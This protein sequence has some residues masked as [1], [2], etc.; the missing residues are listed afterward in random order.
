MERKG[1]R[2]PVS[3]LPPRNENKNVL[4]QA[5]LGVVGVGKSKQAPVV[6][7]SGFSK[8]EEV[9]KPLRNSSTA[10]NRQSSLRAG[11]ANQSEE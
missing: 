5:G 9:K 1:G 6:S 2:P 11:G 3:R 10:I 8:L 7:N 4:G